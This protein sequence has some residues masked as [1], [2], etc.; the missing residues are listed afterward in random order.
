MEKKELKKPIRTM[1]IILNILILLVLT[2][3]I[4]IWYEMA[5][6]GDAPPSPTIYDLRIFEKSILLWVLIVIEFHIFLKTTK[7]KSTT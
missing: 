5:I 2:V 3:F 7:N 1:C 6:V 4:F